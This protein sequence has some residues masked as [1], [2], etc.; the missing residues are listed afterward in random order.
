ML[1]C[2]D[3]IHRIVNNSK[4]EMAIFNLYN[5]IIEYGNSCLLITGNKAS[6]KLIN[7]SLPDLASRITGAD[8]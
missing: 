1:V 8:I 3:N 2:I 4:W 6:P 7:I 5:R